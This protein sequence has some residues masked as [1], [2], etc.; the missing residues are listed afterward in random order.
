MPVRSIY[1]KF[2]QHFKVPAREAYKWCTDYQPG[3]L[4]LMGEKG[5]R[6]ID[7]ISKDAFILSDTL[8]TKVNGKRKKVTKTKL[9]RL[10]TRALSWT[11]THIAGPIRHSQFL[12]R[13]VPEGKNA[14]RL[15]FT[16]L[17]IESGKSGGKTASELAKKYRA[18]DS[19]GWK[20]LAK[21]LHKDL[22]S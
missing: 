15:E 17:Q 20:L 3:D 8:R 7:W 9:V 10:N 2:T 19:R 1:Y 5:T 18:E 14:S 16:G 12:Y 4:A 22:L 11:N 6:K 21:A 13:I